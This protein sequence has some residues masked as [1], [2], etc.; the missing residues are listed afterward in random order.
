[1]F[2]FDLVP[3]VWAE[4][5]KLRITGK[6]DNYILGHLEDGEHPPLV[7]RKSGRRITVPVRSNSPLVGNSKARETSP[8]FQKEKVGVKRGFI[9]V[10]P[11][12]GWQ[13]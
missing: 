7:G 5:Q 2:A 11:Q 4:I 8:S 6:K 3:V 1:M 12:A 13:P 10:P 9:P